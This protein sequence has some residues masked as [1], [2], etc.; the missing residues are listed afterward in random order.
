MI[1]MTSNFLTYISGLFCLFLEV[2][3]VSF[4]SV[5]I[6]FPLMTCIASLVS[7]ALYWSI[8]GFC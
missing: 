1:A 8:V 5:I 3:Q 2:S 7:L 6:A 4:A